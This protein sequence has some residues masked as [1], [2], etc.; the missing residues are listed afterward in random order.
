MG[1]DMEM[2]AEERD[3]FRRELVKMELVGGLG[4]S[5]SG[6]GGGGAGNGG[7]GD[8]A[9]GEG[10]EWSDVSASALDGWN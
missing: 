3:F 7:D 9:D 2:L 1:T 10:G 4:G 5:G 8:M 6:G